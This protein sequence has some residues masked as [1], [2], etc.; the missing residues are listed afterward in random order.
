MK[1]AIALAA[2]ALVLTACSGDSNQ[3]LG[4]A[5]DDK[6]SVAAAETK[7]SAEP[8]TGPEPQESLQANSADPAADAAVENSEE[9]LETDDVETSENAPPGLEISQNPSYLPWHDP[10]NDGW[11]LTVE[12]CERALD[13]NPEGIDWSFRRHCEWVSMARW[14]TPRDTC[15]RL[16]DADFP[17]DTRVEEIC[18]PKTPRL[19][20]C[21]IK[22]KTSCVNANLSGAQLN[23]APLRESNLSGANLRGANLSGASLVN[24]DLRGADLTGADLS[25]A[26]MFG[27]NLLGATLSGVRISQ[28]DFS[29]AVWTDG[30]RCNAPSPRGTCLHTQV[31]DLARGLR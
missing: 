15:R 1:V 29:S 2:A 14:V 5:G 7:A 28:T 18:G 10:N 11:R 12:L 13:K 9:L 31:I 21:A 20:G 17:W 8:S 23:N 19:N 16:D 4:L 25:N 30:R 6:N 27:V 26:Q 24:S 3:A 22:S